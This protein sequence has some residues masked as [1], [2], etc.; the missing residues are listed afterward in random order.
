MPTTRCAKPGANSATGRPARLGFALVVLAFLAGCATVVDPDVC[1]RFDAARAATSYDTVYRYS[2]EDTRNAA[3][4]FRPLA[5]KT[6]VAVRWYTLRLSSDEVPRCEHLYLYKDLYL[7]RD[8]GAIEIEEQREFY[9]AAGKLV[10]SKKER[11]TGQLRR[12]GYYAAS[13]PLPIPEAAPAGRYRVITR[14]VWR[15]PGG[16]DQTLA[17]ASAEFRVAR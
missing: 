10:A 12:G 17:T 8:T 5:R 6:P 7:E 16:K 2:E 4:H 11:L 9:T 13:V 1:A 15:V 3:R 14:L